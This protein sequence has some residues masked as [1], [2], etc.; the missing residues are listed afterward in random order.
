MIE[1]ANVAEVEQRRIHD[2]SLQR[3]PPFID[4]E[5]NIGP[6]IVHGG[7]DVPSM[8]DDGIER[9]GRP[10]FDTGALDGYEDDESSFSE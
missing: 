4:D 3:V 2:A 1:E 6:H 10:S 5:H 8:S 9:I 7:Q